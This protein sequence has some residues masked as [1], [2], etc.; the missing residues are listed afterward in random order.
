MS[1]SE[2]NSPSLFCCANLEGVAVP[3]EQTEQFSEC[4]VKA[5]GG[6]SERII[7]RSVSTCL[8][9]LSKI[10]FCDRLL[11]EWSETATLLLNLI[12]LKSIAKNIEA[13]KRPQLLEVYNTWCSSVVYLQGISEAL[14]SVACCC[15]HPN[16]NGTIAP[17]WVWLLAT[18][19]SQWTVSRLKC[20]GEYQAYETYAWFARLR[21]NSVQGKRF[22]SWQHDWCE[23]KAT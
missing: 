11:G 7:H 18:V 20:R 15:H 16:W 13:K 1:C 3:P 12:S 19:A 17:W 5:D 4:V 8:S 14:D 2:F 23:I 9:S 21:S 22:Q 6:R 10:T